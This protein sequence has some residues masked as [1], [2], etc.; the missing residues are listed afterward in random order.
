MHG[1]LNT[2]IHILR[3][4]LH[5]SFNNTAALYLPHCI[6][7]QS[8]CCRIR[9]YTA[10]QRKEFCRCQQNTWEGEHVR[11]AQGNL[12]LSFDEHERSVLCSGHFTRRK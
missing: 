6:L 8:Y 7:L 1:Q 5:Q 2:I 9:K 4:E 12:N 3:L 11:V 10:E